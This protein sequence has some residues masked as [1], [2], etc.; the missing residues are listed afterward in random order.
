MSQPLLFFCDSDCL[1]QIF[2][3][4]QIPLLKWL[5]A[6]YGV[7]TVI[8]PEVDY[9]VAWTVRFKD[10]FDRQLKKAL[11]SGVISIFDYSRPEQL[12]SLLSSPQAVITAKAITQT[13]KGYALRVGAGE[14]YSHAACIHL[15]KHLL[16][17]DKSAIKTLRSQGLTTAAPVLRLFDL[18]C[19][20]YRRGHMSEKD[21]DAVRQEL[22]LR[23]RSSFRV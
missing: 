17:H 12:S 9:E 11:S 23:P 1:I 16:S 21:C 22:V 5:K 4:N 6:A 10:R 14:A 7:K 3:S 8:V 13:G 20:A 15:G 19:L 2:I 18:I